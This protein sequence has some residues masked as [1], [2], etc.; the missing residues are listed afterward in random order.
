MGIIDHDQ[1]TLLDTT[2][3]Q[4]TH[5]HFLVVLPKSSHA[6]G[7]GLVGGPATNIRPITFSHIS[8]FL[9]FDYLCVFQLI[10]DLVVLLCVVL[11]LVNSH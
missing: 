9:S 6:L 11:C 1:L 8:I 5:I 7:V 3:V 10:I 2:E 4:T